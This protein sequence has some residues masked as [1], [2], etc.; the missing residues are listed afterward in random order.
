MFIYSD[1]IYSILNFAKKFGICIPANP[2]MLVKIDGIKG[3]DANYSIIEDG[4]CGN[5]FAYNMSPI[6]FY[7]KNENAR[8]L[9]E[10]YCEIMKENPARGPLNMWRAVWKT[11]VNPHLLPFQWCVC[12]EHCAIGNEII[13]HVGHDK[14]K[15]QYNI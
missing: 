8:T 10:E 15:K 2:R 9:L 4:S 14:V 1:E 6:V 3:A 12:A 5:G 13:L 7:T 11:G